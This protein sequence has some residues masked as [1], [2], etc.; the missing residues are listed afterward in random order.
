MEAI[1]FP[2]ITDL[3]VVEENKCLIERH[4]RS[5]KYLNE[6]EVLEYCY[7]NSCSISSP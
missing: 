6:I 7:F 3:H 2:F 1:A 5:L 4:E